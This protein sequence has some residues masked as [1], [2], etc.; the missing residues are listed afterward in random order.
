MEDDANKPTPHTTELR[1]FVTY[2]LARL[3]AKLNS[4]AIRKL[5]ENSEFSLTEW[6][7]VAVS[8]LSEDTTLSALTALTELDKGQLSRGVSGL[9][10]KGF[11]TSTVNSDDH[12]RNVLSLTELGRAEHDRIMPV[13]RERQQGLTKELSAEDLATL[14][15]C[16]SLLEDAATG[17]D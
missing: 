7:I 5:R 16:I 3:Q 15:R 9:V 17:N 10:E 12:R 11:L 6:R 4:Q 1:Q 2:R 13:M 8:A 14:Q